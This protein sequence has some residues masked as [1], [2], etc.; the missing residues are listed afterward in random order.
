[1]RP[2]QVPPAR[3]KSEDFLD[4][5]PPVST[6]TRVG[7]WRDRQGGESHGREHATQDVRDPR[8]PAVPVRRRPRRGAP[9]GGPAPRARQKEPSP[10]ATAPPRAGFHR[11]DTNG[12]VPVRPIHGISTFAA[13]HGCRVAAGTH[14]ARGDPAVRTS[15]SPCGPATA[16]YPAPP[17]RGP[18]A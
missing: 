12:H 7:T 1:G 15:E 10:C 8:L 9:V 6:M 18:L 11:K 4:I 17:G 16:R 5:A 13:P 3:G 14:E 2:G